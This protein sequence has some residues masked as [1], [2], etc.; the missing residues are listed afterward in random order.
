AAR[1]RDVRYLEPVDRVVR[2]VANGFVLTADRFG[3]AAIGDLHV[4]VEEAQD[5]ATCRIL[6]HVVGGDVA[7]AR[8]RAGLDRRRAGGLVVVLRTVRQDDAVGTQPG[9]AAIRRRRAVAA[10][11]RARGVAA[12]AVATGGG[13]GDVGPRSG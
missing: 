1:H 10:G 13:C 9:V 12:G 8:G 4:L 11:A 2:V 3:R 7:L 6:G 5:R